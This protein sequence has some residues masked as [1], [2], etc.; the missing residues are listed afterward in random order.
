MNIEQSSTEVDINQ[1]NQYLNTNI[2]ELLP[3][4]LTRQ[5]RIDNFFQEYNLLK[6]ELPN[7]VTDANENIVDVTDIYSQ[8]YE[9]GHDIAQAQDNPEAIVE[10]EASFITRLNIHSNQINSS[11]TLQSL[12]NDLNEYLK[13]YY[14]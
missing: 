4:R 3:D 2:Y 5:Q 8:Q 9:L 6:G 13:R 10:E 7:Y 1:A 12:R 11:K 14:I